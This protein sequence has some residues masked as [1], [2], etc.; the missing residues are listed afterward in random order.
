MAK[1][2]EK[3]I[4]KLRKHVH[5]SG[6]AVLFCAMPD[7]HYKINPALALGKRSICW[8]CGEEFIMNEYSLRLTKPHCEKCH[9]PKKN[10]NESQVEIQF[11]PPVMQTMIEHDSLSERL[12]RAINAPKTTVEKH[13]EVVEDEEL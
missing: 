10:K 8:R 1:T 9:K 12:R 4:H 6:N 7:C 11:I 5:K 3:H 2:A 13:D